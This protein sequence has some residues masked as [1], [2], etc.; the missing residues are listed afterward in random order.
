MKA[1]FAVGVRVVVNNCF[2]L[3][4]H[5]TVVRVYEKAYEGATQRYLVQFDNEGR[6]HCEESELQA[7]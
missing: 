5:G 3:Y 4:D 6:E 7:E 2:G 1:K